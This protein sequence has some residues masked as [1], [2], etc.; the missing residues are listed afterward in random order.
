MST[1]AIIMMVISIAVLWGGLITAV[2]HLRRHP[3]EPETE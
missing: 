1:S 2:L 3:D